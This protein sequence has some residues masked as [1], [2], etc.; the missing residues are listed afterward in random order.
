MGQRDGRREAAR[1]VQLDVD[2][3]VL[4]C[5]LVQGVEAVDGFIRADGDGAGEAAQRFVVT[6]GQRLLDEFDPRLGTG[7]QHLAKVR[8]RPALIGIDDEAAL[9]RI[10]ADEPEPLRIALA[11]ELQLEERAVRR[12]RRRFA[13]GFGRVEAQR[14]GGDDGLRFRQAR[15][16]PGG[17]SGLL[18]AQVPQGAVERV[19][20]SVRA[21][22]GG[23]VLEGDA[24][25]DASARRFERLHHL[26]HGFLVA[27]VGHAFAVAGVAVFS[28]RH[29]HHMGL[30]FGAA[31]NGEA[32][33]DGPAF[34]GDRQLRHVSARSG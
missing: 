28:Q 3:V 30:G 13:H 11:S 31:R 24:R 6:R 25:L 10:A 33:G 18:G 1:L 27:R 16:L 5:K 26:R 12:L 17:L 4:A 23:D 7:F 19:P 14:I 29:R 8:G 22:Q 21:E 34:L 32:A 15:Q 9:R 2:C 20:R